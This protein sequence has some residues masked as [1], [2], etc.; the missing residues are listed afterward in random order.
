VT[1]LVISEKPNAAGKI[2]AALSPR[3]KAI[4]KQPTVYELE[5]KGQKIFVAPAVGHVYGLKPVGKGSGYPVFD[6]EWAP[7]PDIDERSAYVAPYLAA[8]QKYAKLADEV[9]NACD[10]DTEGALIG[11][12][13]I[14]FNAP[15]K[16]TSRMRFSTLVAEE[17]ADAFDNREKLDVLNAQAGEARHVLDWFWGI[18]TS[19]A[20]M[21][22]IKKA[23]MFRVMS[24][25]RVQGPSLD[26]LA[27]RE[28]EI[29]QFKPEPF[30]Q[31]MTNGDGVE[32]WHVKDKFFNEKECDSAFEKANKGKH[33]AAI[34]SV[35]RRKFKTLPP[36]PFDLTSLQIEAY[37]VFGYS[38]SMT[39]ELAQRLY[40]AGLASYPRTSSQKLPAK[41]NLK[42]IVQSL[43]EQPAYKKLAGML[44]GFKPHEGEKND[45][46]HPAIHPTGLAAKRM[47]EYEQK[48]YD[49]IVKRFLASMGE[50]AERESMKVILDIG[51]EKFDARGTRVVTPG[52]IEVYDPYGNF[53]DVLL[54]D[55]KEKQKVK[56]EKI[57]KLQKETKPPSRYSQA[58]LIK[59]L[60]DQ[61]LGTKATR[62]SIIQTLYDRSYITGKSIQVTALGMTVIHSLSHHVPEVLSEQLTRAFEHEMEKITEG[63]YDKDK[64]IEEGKEALQK[65]LTKFKSQEEAVGKELIEGVRETERTQSLLGKCNKCAEGELRIRRSRFGF[66]VGCSKYPECKNIFP[67]PRQAAITATGKVCEKCNTPMIVVVRKMRKT[68]KMCLDP[69]CETKADWGKAKEER[70]RKKAEKEEAKKQAQTEEKKIEEAKPVKAKVTKP[71]KAKKT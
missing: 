15:K 41:L 56:I 31:I 6:V 19:R 64:V 47:N 4:G 10:F 51:G 67:L 16:K 40:E 65:I 71:K 38:P 20:L 3:A 9:V 54:P 25:G 68:F 63:N 8:L 17:L 39:L 44:K 43:A 33:A 62:A 22:S 32:F 27:K 34:D 58:S 23:G 5:R 14:R 26:V 28:T 49:L 42:K 70:A 52:W 59:E 35:E 48:I 36:F 61:D 30:W 18:N 57:E 46:A 37:R 53:E 13:I 45:P 2:A 24:I 21:A 29:L 69:H 55:F 50:E 12:N 60:E 11:Y 66:F 1:I 7:S